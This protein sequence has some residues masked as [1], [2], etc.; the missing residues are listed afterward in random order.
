MTRPVPLSELGSLPQVVDLL[1][2]AGLLGIGRTTAYQL[3]RNGRFPVPVVRIGARCKVPTEPLLDLLGRPSPEAGSVIATTPTT[4]AGMV[5]V[6]VPGSRSARVGRAEPGAGALRCAVC[7]RF[8]G[9]V[10][11]S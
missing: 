3:A 2:A 9:A 11:G 6:P 8:F 1:T 10:E 7:G 5:A 4:A